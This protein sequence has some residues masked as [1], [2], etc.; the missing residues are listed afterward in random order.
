MHYSSKPSISPPTQEM[1]RSA[2]ES[3]GLIG[4]SRH[5]STRESIF[6]QALLAA[7]DIPEVGK[8]IEILSG[9]IPHL[10]SIHREG[11]ISQVL[12]SL[13][14]LE[15][16]DFVGAVAK[17]APYVTEDL[18]RNLLVQAYT[19]TAAIAWKRVRA[20]LVAQLIPYLRR[21]QQE[22]SLEVVRDALR[23]EYDIVAYSVLLFNVL[24]YLPN[25]A[26]AYELLSTV[27]QNDFI[28]MQIADAANRTHALL[29]LLPFARDEQRRQMVILAVDSVRGVRE[30]FMRSL[31][32]GR[33]APYLEGHLLKGVLE[34]F[35][36][37]DDSD[38]LA[39]ALAELVSLP[40]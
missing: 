9:L 5:D 27:L 1:A 21:E 7:M 20:N 36:R 26:L 34:D 32:C 24:S 14:Q 16:E 19:M 30:S 11:A 12:T 10:T 38:V 25:Q 35:R 39:K 3:L 33:L 29:D 2:A 40:R 37:I 31:N 13:S 18:Q 22:E 4:Q 6:P 28:P 8:R 17:I 23:D 15:D